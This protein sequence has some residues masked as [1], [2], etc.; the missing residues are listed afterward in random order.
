VLKTLTFTVIG[1]LTAIAGGG[2][3]LLVQIYDVK[4]TVADTKRDVANAVERIAKLEGTIGEVKPGQ[5]SITGSLARIETA[6]KGPPTPPPATDV[7]AAASDI[8]QRYSG[9]SLS[10]PEVRS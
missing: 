6:L 9:D 4:S 1:F 5:G 3:F 7:G 10:A 2:I 8:D